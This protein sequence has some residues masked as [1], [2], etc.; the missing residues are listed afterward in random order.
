MWYMGMMIM[1]K[2]GSKGMD[3]LWGE[4]GEGGEDTGY[5]SLLQTIR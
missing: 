5:R 3:V 2:Q 4:G 1:R